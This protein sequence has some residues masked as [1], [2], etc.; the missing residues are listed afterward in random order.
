ML[1]PPVG[2]RDTV[3]GRNSDSDPNRNA[4]SAPTHSNS[5]TNCNT[6]T[7]P[8]P[9]TESWPSSDPAQGSASAQTMNIP[10]FDSHEFL[11]FS[12][13]DVIQT[14]VLI[15]GVVLYFS[16]GFAKSDT[17][18]DMN[19]QNIGQLTS[20]VSLLTTNQHDMDINGTRHSSQIDAVQQR[21]IDEN[22]KRIEASEQRYTQIYDIL[23][24]VKSE[25]GKKK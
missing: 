22:T 10:N 16:T 19:A 20:A 15:V 21:Q 4:N 5:D 6:H 13:R 8:Y 3:H 14:G 11:R 24:S 18:A 1:S 9:D 25:I 2:K 7:N 23:T 12:L 17:K